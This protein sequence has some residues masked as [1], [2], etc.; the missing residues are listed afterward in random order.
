MEVPDSTSLPAVKAA[1]G[2]D[3]SKGRGAFISDAVDDSRIVGQGEMQILQIPQPQ[4]TP[5]L[6]LFLKSSH[7]IPVPP[8]PINP[9]RIPKLS[10]PIRTLYTF[11]NISTR[12]SHSHYKAL[13]PF[14]RGTILK[15]MPTIPF[16]SS[17]FSSSSSPKMSYPVQKT[18]NE[19]RAVLSKGASH[20]ITRSRNPL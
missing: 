18:D 19:W 17:F 6:P 2:S 15:S 20:Y 8:S 7:V 4:N 1:S 11:S 13:Q 9:M 14:T 5:Y 16:L 3:I 10:T 12:L